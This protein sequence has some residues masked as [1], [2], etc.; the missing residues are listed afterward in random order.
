[1]QGVKIRLFSISEQRLIIY[2]I[3]YSLYDY[4]LCELA[5]SLTKC[6]NKKQKQKMRLSARL[7]PDPLWEFKRSLDNWLCPQGKPFRG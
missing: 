1:L 2:T 4:K 6:S 3:L 7:R 5:I